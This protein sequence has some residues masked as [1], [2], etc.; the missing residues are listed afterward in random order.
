MHLRL[1][2]SDEVNVD[3]NGESKLRAVK[4]LCL[5]V[6]VSNWKTYMA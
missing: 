5:N 2:L 6:S 1:L 4:W 3:A